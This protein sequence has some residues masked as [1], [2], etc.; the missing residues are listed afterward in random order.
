MINAAIKAFFFLVN[1]LFGLFN[2]FFFL[3]IPLFANL[4]F[5]SGKIWGMFLL[6]IVSE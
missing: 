6:E 5:F 4:F 2:T 3:L 1:G